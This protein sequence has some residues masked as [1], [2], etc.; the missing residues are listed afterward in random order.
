MCL[1]VPLQVKEIK[2]Q[3]AIVTL[4][5]VE[6]QISI[7]M[8]PDVQ[9]GSWVLVHAGFSI[10]EL[11]EEDALENLRLLRELSEAIEDR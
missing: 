11:S 6:R 7:V 1:A 4:N 2:E 3:M 8:T 10:Q 5:E 9:V